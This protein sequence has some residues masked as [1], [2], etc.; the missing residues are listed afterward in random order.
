M[1]GGV[2]KPSASST[3]TNKKKEPEIKKAS[4]GGT[5]IDSNAGSSTKKVQNNPGKRDCNFIVNSILIKN[6]R[7]IF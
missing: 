6:Y 5:K 3:N 4:I 1:L 2:K 7:E